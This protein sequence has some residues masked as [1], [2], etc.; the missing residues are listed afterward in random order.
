[1]STLESQRD[2][3]QFENEQLRRRIADLETGEKLL[4]AIVE[5]APVMIGLLRAPDFVFEVANPALQRMFPGRQLLGKRFADIWGDGPTV[6]RCNE[7]IASGEPAQVTDAAYKFHE[8]DGRLEVIHI[9]YSLTPLT[10]PEGKR[11]RILAM[12]FETTVAVRQ[13]RELEDALARNRAI[14]ESISDGMLIADRQ[15]NILAMNPAGAQFHRVADASDALRHVS[16]FRA[17]EFLGQDG[18]TL[19]V[20]EWPISRVMRGET[21]RNLQVSIR[22]RDTGELWDSSYSGTPIRDQHGSVAMI[23]LTFRD[24]TEKRQAHQALKKAHREREMYLGQLVAVIDS[25]SEGL[26]ACNLDGRLFH[27]NPAALAMYGFPRPEDAQRTLAE[28][29]DILELST[30]EH[31]ALPLDRWPLSRILKGETLRDEVIEV[32][33]RDRDWKRTFSYSGTF[34]RDEAGDPIVAVLTVTDITA[35][36][37]AQEELRKTDAL[38]R[39]ICENTPDCVFLKDR[40]LRLIFVNAAGLRVHGRP[41]EKLFGRAPAELH[42]EPA[43]AATIEQHDREVMRRGETMEFEETVITAAGQRTFLATKTPWRDDNGNVIGIIGVCHDITERNRTQAALRESEEHRRLFIEYAPAPIAMLD[44]EMRYLAV[45]RRW[46]SDFNISDGDIRG[47][48]HYD[49][50]PDLPQRWREVHQRCLAGAVERCE[51]DEYPRADGTLDWLRWE[52]HPWRKA[53][54][55]VGGII[56]FSEVITA[57][58]EADLALRASNRRLE[59]LSH[60]LDLAQAFVRTVDGTILVWTAGAERLYGFSKEEAVGKNSF[61][62]LQPG[63]PQTIRE[64]EEELHRTGHWTGILNQVCRD[65]RLIWVSSQW[66]VHHDATGEPTEVIEVQQDITERRRAEEVALRWQHAFERAELGISLGDANKHR[67]EAVNAAFARQRGYTPDE[68]AGQPIESMYPPEV[69]SAVMAQVRKADGPAGHALYESIQVRKDGSRFPV[70]VDLTSIR[71]DEG[72]PVS[73][74]AYVLDL[75]ERKLAEAEILNL[76]AELEQR[77]RQRTAE[78]AASNQEL[79]SFSYSV[80]HD[81]RAPLRGIDGWSLAL[82]EDYGFLLDAPG[83][84]YLSRIRSETQH[85]GHLISDLLELSRVTR[86]EMQFQHVDL[87][88]IATQV[89]VR[90]AESHPDRTIQFAIEPALTAMGDSR[91][92]QIVL[93]N[94]MDNAVKFTSRRTDACVA[95]GRSEQDGTTVFYIRD[96]GVGFDMAHAD[97]LFGAFQQLHKPSEFPGSGIGL[98]TV[99]RVIRRH[100][101]RVWAEAERGRGAAFFFT[102][103]ETK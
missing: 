69:R 17:F 92:L 88:A 59:E 87:T 103:G 33:R 2:S 95:V 89:S 49:V 10:G 77:V 38:L 54:G 78:L 65:G 15:G 30:R 90:L 93:T 91:L 51:E 41:A 1:M 86:T 71:D 63:G 14:F 64:I 100:C 50:M 62:L 36:R 20:D 28:L 58:K 83:K 74:I 56:I 97:L 37:R 26:I 40:D 60:T 8:A 6:K 35:Q 57:R 55:A 25:L 94:L 48:S 85:M 16:D 46:M 76:N 84:Q 102:V 22:R 75:T 66:A 21:L 73:R 47:R 70:L 101:G 81:L 29:A 82:L 45:S 32:R 5:N 52:I 3:L 27:W 79:E 68:L 31:E 99:Q 34:A 42:A 61:D 96:N 9:T 67:F 4:R 19:D 23:V 7:V 44:R 80:S 72:H 12:G 98:A 39:V 53:D 11:D 18:R 43:I 13:R 24:N